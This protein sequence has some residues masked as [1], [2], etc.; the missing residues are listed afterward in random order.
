MPR[1]PEAHLS[2]GFG[3]LAFSWTVLEVGVL[4][5]VICGPVW[6]RTVLFCSPVLWT[7][8]PLWPWTCFTAMILTLGWAWLWSMGL[9]GSPRSVVVGWALGSE[10]PALPA[11]FLYLAP[12]SLGSSWLLGP[13]INVLLIHFTTF[14]PW[15]LMLASGCCF[16]LGINWKRKIF[17]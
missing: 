3:A 7:G 11:G 5:S 9:P 12:W 6:S 2:S 14:E 10:A 16:T 1:G 17:I 15:F 13:H 4:F 8:F